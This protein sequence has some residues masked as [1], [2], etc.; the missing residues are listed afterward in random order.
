MKIFWGRERFAII[1][2]RYHMKNVT[3]NLNIFN[4]NGAHNKVQLQQLYEITKGV[5][6]HGL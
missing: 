6:R 2:Y 5:A 4:K 3:K 1:C